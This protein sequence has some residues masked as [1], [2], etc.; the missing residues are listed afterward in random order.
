VRTPAVDFAAA[1]RGLG[2]RAWSVAAGEALES[3]L[4]TAFAEDGPTLIDITTDA[5]GYGAQLAAL[6]G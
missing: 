4:R 3:V 5:S 6:R 1:A 2:C